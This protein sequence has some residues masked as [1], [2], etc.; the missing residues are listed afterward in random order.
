L[1]SKR[2]NH[3]EAAS[4]YHRYI[5]ITVLIALIAF[6]LLDGTLVLLLIEFCIWVFNIFC[7]YKLAQAIGRS[8][9]VWAVLGLVGFFL[10]CIPQLLLLNETNKAFEAQGMKIGFLAARPKWQKR[11]EWRAT[12]NEEVA[13]TYGNF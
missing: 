8:A 5:V 7:C 10:F 11:W 9:V 1:L 3:I 4:T 13:A 6:F 12:R 2:P